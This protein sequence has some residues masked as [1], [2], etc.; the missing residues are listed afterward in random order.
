VCE[1]KTN[2]ENGHQCDLTQGNLWQ[3]LENFDQDLAENCRDKGC[4]VCGGRLHRAR[5]RRKPR[6]LTEAQEQAVCWRD[7]FCCEREGCRKRHTPPSVRFLGR[8][9]YAAVVVVLLAAMCHGLSPGRVEL[10]RK[11][12]KVDRRTLERWRHWWL[13][14]F[15]QSRFWK[16]LR[17]RFPGDLD[18]H[19]LPLSLCR[20]FGIQ[21]SDRWLDLLRFLSPLSASAHLTEHGC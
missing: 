3:L 9:V 7:S 21:R 13:E 4:L 16:A 8:R 20:S 11:G 10:L 6:G 15:A 1:K 17:P 5:Y 18:P 12:L 14:E 19:I 2:K